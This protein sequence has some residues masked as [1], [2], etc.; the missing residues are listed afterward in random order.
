MNIISEGRQD[1]FP[2]LLLHGLGAN[3]ESWYFQI[4]ALL[5][6]GYRVIAPDLP[7]FGKSIFEGDQWN[8]DRVTQ[9]LVQIL[10]SAGIKKMGLMGIS[11]GGVIGLKLAAEYPDLVLMSVLVN[12]FAVLRPRRWNEFRYFVRRGVRAF[13]LSPQAQAELVASRIFPSDD[14]RLFREMLTQS[15]KQ[16]DP[17]VYRQAMLALTRFDGRELAKRIT[18]PVLVVSGAKDTTIPLYL[19]KRLVE[20]LPN[21]GHVIIEGGGHALPIDQPGVFNQVMLSFYAN[22]SEMVR[23]Y[24]SKS[25]NGC[26]Q[27]KF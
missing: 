20:L 21:G 17:K 6:A 3:A 4:P 7:G 11:M 23:T 18:N 10:R 9:E 24:C 26:L 27:E 15:I 22:P 12:T 1:G 14:K 25:T 8:F 13:F 2:I 19:Q 16:A 5:D